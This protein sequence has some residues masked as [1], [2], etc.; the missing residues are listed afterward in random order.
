MYGDSDK[1]ALT[2]NH[3]IPVS[4]KLTIMDKNLNKYASKPSR[5]MDCQNYPRLRQFRYKENA[6]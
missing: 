5:K 3:C 6:L 2:S 1:V 4:P